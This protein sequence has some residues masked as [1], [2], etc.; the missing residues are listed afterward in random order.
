MQTQN[1]PPNKSFLLGCSLGHLGAGWVLLLHTLDDS[2]SNCLPHVTNSETTKRRV[3]REGL[4]HHGLGGNHLN[5][6]SITVLEELGLLL[7]LLTRSPVDLG[8]ELSKLD[9]Y[10]GGVAVQHW[11]VA[12]ANLSRVVHDDDLGG[13]AGSLLGRVILGVGGHIPTL[14][15]LHSNVLHVEANIVTRKGLLESLVVHLHRL[16]LSSQTAGTKGNNHTR[17][18][19]TGL[20]T[21]NRDSSNTTNLVHILKGET[22]GLVR[23]PLGLVDLVKSLK[24]GW[25]L[26]PVKVGGPLNHVVT[27][28][29]RD[30]DEGDLIRVVANLL[31]VGGDFLHNFIIT[32]LGVLGSGG[33]HL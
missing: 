17:L 20:N 15:I 27:L 14:Q 31:E 21:A 28:K 26:V 32:G 23:R 24:Q 25:A 16:H 10:V 13:E 5:H 19:D 1:Q 9:G 7:K 11:G 12:V 3:L 2:N 29:T 33:I 8:N 22:Q 30:G 4:H 6:T 18:D